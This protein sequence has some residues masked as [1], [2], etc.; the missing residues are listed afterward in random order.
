MIALTRFVPKIKLLQL[1]KLCMSRWS[2]IGISFCNKW[3]NSSIKVHADFRS[4]ITSNS[5]P[6]V[7][8]VIKFEWKEAFRY[9]RCIGRSHDYE[10]SMLLC[11]DDRRTI[12]SPAV[13]IN[14]VFACILS[15]LCL[16]K[17]V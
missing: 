8:D 10:S 13:D 17:Q 5:L 11:K 4:Q 3:N 14:N 9:L 16:L 1:G 15:F 7:Y 12:T 6:F 2:P